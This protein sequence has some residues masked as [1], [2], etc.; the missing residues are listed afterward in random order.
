MEQAF[1]GWVGVLWH[2]YGLAEKRLSQTEGIM[3]TW[4]SI[5][6]IF[7]DEKISSKVSELPKVITWITNNVGN[8]TRSSDF[9][10]LCTRMPVHVGQGYQIKISFYLLLYS[11]LWDGPCLTQLLGVGREM[12]REEDLFNAQ[13][14]PVR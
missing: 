5:I 9:N 3:Y 2:K 10:Q 12:I 13:I 14:N 4:W 1:E 7:K 6:P 8:R 11:S